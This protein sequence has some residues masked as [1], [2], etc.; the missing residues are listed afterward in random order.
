MKTRL[1]CEQSKSN[2]SLEIKSSCSDASGVAII[3][4]YFLPGTNPDTAQVQVQN[5][6]QLA[7]PSLPQTVQQQGVVVAK[8]T[9]NFMMF[10]T[11]STVDD[12]L[13][14]VALGNYIASSVLDPIRRVSGVGE[15]NMFGS[16]YAM[17]VWINPDKLNSFGLTAGDVITAIQNQNAQVPVGQIGD[18]PA[19]EGQELNV[20]M[21]GRT[22]LRTVPEFENVLLRTNPDGSR[23]LLKDVARVALGAENYGTQARVNGHLSAAVAIK[24]S[25]TAN[26]LNT[27]QAVREKVA[28]LARFFP[29]GVRVDYSLDTSTFVRISIEEV[30][31]TLVQAIA[32]V[33]LVMYLLLQ[34][35][36]A[37]LIS[38]FV[39]P[40]A[41]L[42]TFDS[43]LSIRFAITVLTM[44]GMVLAIGILVDD[45]IV[46][47]ENV[48]RIM[49]EEG[50]SPRDATG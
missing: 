13:D 3:T 44:F 31:K 5:K 22:T 12:S 16:Q 29:P 33:F 1:N 50:L 26:A 10:F 15:A 20:I 47:V 6:L 4:L 7:T 27:A 49:A 39:V 38:T 9:R 37:T 35:I 2:G 36:R 14:E 34:N 28:D 42:G 17:R 21:Q 32:L 43:M 24:L 11:L 40:V 48:E 41:L 18:K 23:V 25:P 19:V 8:A 45:A 46:V 30:L